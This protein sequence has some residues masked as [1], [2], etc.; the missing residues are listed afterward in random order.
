MRVAYRLGGETLVAA[1]ASRA[2]AERFRPVC[3]ANET[4]DDAATTPAIDVTASDGAYVVRVTGAA[5]LETTEFVTALE[6]YE[7]AL[8]ERLTAALA[9]DIH[10]HAGGAVG[11]RGA[12]LVLGRSGAGKSSIAFSWT[13]FGF[14]ALGDDIVRVDRSGR[15]APFTRIFKIP[16]R[17]ARE[18]GIAVESTIGW[19][20]D[21]HEVWVD[22]AD[23][24]GWGE[25]SPVRL[26]AQARYVPGAEASV[27]RWS[28]GAILAALMES[29]LPTG[30]RGG[31]AFE[32]LAD[33]AARADGYLVTY[34][35]ADAAAALLAA[36]AAGD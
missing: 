13:R 10:L 5:P 25:A 22:P 30:C 34:G 31:D 11:P 6:A 36:R 33:V 20:A 4:A 26:V 27:E 15:A 17:V 14:P 32:R 7:W 24:P 29:V 3:R 12:M 9:S 19:R 21:C 8:T 2:L 28:R 1:F 16:D 18:A 35:R 23:G